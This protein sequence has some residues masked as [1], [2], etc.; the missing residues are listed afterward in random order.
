M[1]TFERKEIET[2][3]QHAEK[4]VDYLIDDEAKKLCR[5]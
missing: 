1:R 4:L 3:I 2:L 5:V